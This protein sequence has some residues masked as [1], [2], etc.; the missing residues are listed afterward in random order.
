[1]FLSLSVGEQSPVIAYSNP[2]RNG[3]G[4]IIGVAVLSVRATALWDLL[5]SI[6][7][8]AGNASYGVLLDR[9]GIRVA[10]G[11]RDDLLFRPAGPLAPEEIARLVAEKR[12]DTRTQELLS[13]PARSPVQ[14]SLAR[15]PFIETEQET[16]SRYVAANQSW[17]LSVARRLSEVPWT[18][19]VLVPESSVYAPVDELLLIGLGSALVIAAL[20]LILG[21]ALSK[22]ILA[23]LREVNQAA[24]ALT[25][26]QLDTRVAVN[27]GDEVG[28]LAG[29]F[30][31][32]AASLETNQS[33]LEDRV[34][35]RT[36]ELER[37][38]E[39][40][41][42]Q[43][44]ELI[45]QRAELQAQQRELELKNDQAL[46]ADKLKSEFL[47]NMS[48]ELRT[49]LNSII[50]F[51]ELLLD[52]A[53]P[54]LQARHREFIEDVLGSGRHL[55]ALIN[56]ILDL[57]KIEAGQ[58]ELNRRPEIARDVLDEAC[59]LVQPTFVKKRLRL[60]RKDQAR[61]EVLVDRGK[62]LQVM[63]NLLSNAA[64]FSP[65]DTEV[66]V[67]CQDQN[68]GKPMVR[69][70]VRDQGVGIDEQLRSRLFQAFV[71]GESPLT[72]RHQGTG[73]GLAICKRL[74]EQHGGAI[75]VDST[76]G[77]GS[78]FWFTLPAVAGTGAHP[79]NGVNGTSAVAEGQSDG[80]T[81]KDKRPEVLVIDDDPG[82]GT[83]LR[84]MLERAGYRV[85]IA[86][87]AREG[88]V[89]AR[90]R[91]PDAL[92]V[93]LGLPD[94]SGFS[95]I[96]DLS[97][98]ARTRTKPIVVLTAR[99]LSEDER[100]RLRPH[101]EAI[102]RK[103]DLLRA[104]LIG[105]LDRALRPNLAPP[106]SV[107]G[108]ILVVDDHDLNR[109]LVRSIL[110]RRGYEVLQADDGVAGVV[111]AHRSRPDVILMDLAM[112]RKDGFAATRE[113]KA[114]QTTKAIPIVAL[115]AL[116][117]RGDE[118]R[119]L[120]AG[121]DEYLTKPI[122]RKRLEETVERLMSSKRVVP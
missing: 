46:R 84:G 67:G 17:N 65:D 109:E 5:R 63:L 21:F 103:G 55:L 43:R 74:I 48:H 19:F 3:A 107:R 122:D 52:E 118:D 78:T 71:Q 66:E 114:D 20:A 33:E 119:A 60:D 22:R 115:T 4:V 32:M 95:L 89:M 77:K 1:M 53:A 23:P 98:D 42:A 54:A 28:T 49:P 111:M 64:K 56:D 61:A 86:E 30:N 68:G 31:K 40:L 81:L 58:L 47:A 75:G 92:V 105:K 59:Q 113:L 7:D 116:A 72:K 88:L 73:L 69:F 57:S 108:R 79:A 112:P 102:A 36:L 34:K 104:E 15:A 11:T 70:W 37:A 101:V 62:L 110:E 10:H 18:L 25:R 27:T 106:R 44:E 35:Q 93:D 76:P 51:S 121:V 120:A 96:E 14:F 100:S 50:G 26:G 24:A 41:T 85:T 94:A 80:E 29:A 117:M 83:L 2:V 16:V 9:Y 13:R 8:R 87:R 45:T 12:F 6:N 99:D 90:D 97:A 91:S 38:N 82:V 39:E